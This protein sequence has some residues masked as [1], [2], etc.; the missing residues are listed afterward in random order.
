MPNGLSNWTYKDVKEFLTKHSFSLYKT[1]P[2]SHEQW[3]SQDEKSIVDV[4][5]ITGSESYPERT[6][7]SMIRDILPSRL[8][9]KHWREWAETGG[10]CCKTEK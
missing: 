7:E 6:L 9:K 10:H 5:F 8:D 4:N 1:L 3:L 2:G